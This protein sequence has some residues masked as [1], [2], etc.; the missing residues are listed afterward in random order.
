M[1]LLNKLAEFYNMNKDAVQLVIAI[2]IYCIAHRQA[3]LSYVRKKAVI[4]ML[5][6]EKGAEE[7]LLTSGA[8]KMDWV[9]QKAYQKMPAWARLIVNM[10]QFRKIAQS[11]F[12]DAK[13]HIEQNKVTPSDPQ[14][15]KDSTS[16]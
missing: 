1:D 9:V 15:A 11:R 6:A 3:V 14:P 12:D 5:S 4:L 10:D 2:V 7:L 13:W 8:Q 16:A